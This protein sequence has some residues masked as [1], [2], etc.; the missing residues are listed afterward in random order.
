MARSNGL[1]VKVQTTMPGFRPTQREFAAGK[2]VLGNGRKLYK[3][4]R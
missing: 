1:K 4:V 3:D 2:R